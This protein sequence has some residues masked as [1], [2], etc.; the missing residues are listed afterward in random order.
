[1]SDLFTLDQILTYVSAYGPA[2]IGGVIF[3]NAAGIP[4][5]AFFLVIA[6]GAFVRQDVIQWYVA[7]SIALVCVMAGDSFN[8]GLG[9]FAQNWVQQ[10][11]GDNRAWQNAEQTFQ[12]RGGMAIFLTRWLLTPLA[13]PTNLIAGSSGYPFLRFLVYDLAGE[14]VW[15]L[16]YGT[17]GYIFGS[18]WQVVGEALSDLNGL[19]AGLAILGLGLY[20]MRRRKRHRIRTLAKAERTE[21]ERG[22]S[23][24]SDDQA[25][26]PST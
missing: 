10:R 6:T 8:Y 25:P 12:E 17:V 21:A 1:M 3:I 7:L 11:W 16:G 5:P 22:E 24:L 20:W 4:L 14:A 23:P 19:L 26:V 15:L 18:Q 13:I 2:V 9:R